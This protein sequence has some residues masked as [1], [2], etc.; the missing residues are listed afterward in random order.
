[1]DATQRTEF[2]GRAY[3]ARA[4]LRPLTVCYKGETIEA[5]GS[6]AG[7]S[8]VELQSGGRKNNREASVSILKSVRAE[9]LPLGAVVEIDG[10]KFQVARAWG[11]DPTAVAWSYWLDQWAA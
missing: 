6:L 4:A 1:M 11:D 2:L 5:S 8:R 9:A 10:T 7:R 3:A